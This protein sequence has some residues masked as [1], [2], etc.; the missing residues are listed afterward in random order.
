MDAIKYCRL[1]V[2]VL[3]NID[4]A[5]FL[6][7][8]G[9]CGRKEKQRGSPSQLLFFGLVGLLGSCATL[10]TLP[11]LQKS[12]HTGKGFSFTHTQKK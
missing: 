10:P 9:P 5:P 11:Y 4:Q 7:V 8:N 6:Q 12:K 2:P 3:E 1:F